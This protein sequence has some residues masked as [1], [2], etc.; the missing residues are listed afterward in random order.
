MDKKSFY[1][2]PLTEVI[3][4]LKLEAPVC[5]SKI[6]TSGGDQ[7]NGLEDFEFVEW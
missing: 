2:A 5:V 7:G 4:P 1:S 3:G 6:K